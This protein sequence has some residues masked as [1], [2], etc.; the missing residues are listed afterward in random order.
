[1]NRDCRK[2]G[3]RRREDIRRK[4]K[5][6]KNMGGCRE[7]GERRIKMGGCREEGVYKEEGERREEDGWM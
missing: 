5:E 4:E 6:G 3:R 1:M 2:E 7:K